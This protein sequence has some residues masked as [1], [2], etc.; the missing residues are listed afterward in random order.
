MSKNIKK[1][2]KEKM[3]HLFETKGFEDMEVAFGVKGKSDN[4]DSEE[5]GQ[6]GSMETVEDYFN[7]KNK[8]GTDLGEPSAQPAL[9]KVHKEDKKDADDYYKKVAERMVGFQKTDESEPSQIGESI[10]EVVGIGTVLGVAA[11]GLAAKW[12]AGKV[13]NYILNKQFKKTG[14]KEEIKNAEG[15]IVSV[16]YGYEY[17]DGTHYWGVDVQSGEGD[18]GMNEKNT[19]MFKDEKAKDVKNYLSKGGSAQEPGG[20]DG[21]KGYFPKN[22]GPFTADQKISR[23]TNESVNEEFDS[24]KV[25]REDDQT[26]PEDVYSTE[27][28]GTGMQALKYDNEGT[29]VYDK[30]EERMEDLNDGDETYEKLKKYSEKYLKHKYEDPDEYHY[31]P[32]VRVTDK[33]I[34]SEGYS[35]IN[36]ENI[37]KVKGTIKN[38]GQIIKLVDRLPSRVRVDETVFSITDGQNS[39]RL[40]WEGAEDG[41]VIITHEK[42]TNI[43]NESINKMRHLW[44]FK[45]SDSNKKVIK[46]ND[47]VFLKM[48]NK[49]RGKESLNETVAVN[50][51]A[52]KATINKLAK[53]L[54]N[55]ADLGAKCRQLIKQDGNCTQKLK[56]MAKDN[57]NDKDLGAACRKMCK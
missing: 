2:L 1:I 32:K 14:E 56:D 34:K 52:N 40:V 5:A 12:A 26:E 43:V 44:E 38:K 6:F 33:A 39:Y 23:G 3:N 8:K 25:D 15:K 30:F 11:L 20:M 36:K 31:T 50:A 27:A 19:F 55:D 48:M 49:A 51:K 57:P 22:V 54:P 10:N 7:K 13:N 17:K 29:E 35:D 18:E 42:N 37:F 53:G 4:L 24:P 16:M 47:D 41:E 28:L 21:S 45:S 46:E 9:N